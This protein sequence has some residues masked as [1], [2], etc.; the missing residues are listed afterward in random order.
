MLADG[1]FYFDSDLATP[2][3]DL[4]TKLE[5]QVFQDGL[6]SLADK[7]RRLVAL[8]PRLCAFAGLDDLSSV[9]ALAASRCK[10]DL[11]TGC[12]TE[13]PDEMQGIMGGYLMRLQPVPMRRGRAS[14]QPS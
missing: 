7:Q 6:G 14:R 13:F 8:S 1:T 10:L 9:L 4:T 11:Q 3:A 12:V 2:V 5:R